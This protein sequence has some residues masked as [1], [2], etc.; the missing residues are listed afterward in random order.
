MAKIGR[1]D[2]RTDLAVW[3]SE[4]TVL[5]IILMAYLNQHRAHT[6]NTTISVGMEMVTIA[7]S[8]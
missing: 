7:A 1:L 8:L 6:K 5:R 3:W 2:R 4:G